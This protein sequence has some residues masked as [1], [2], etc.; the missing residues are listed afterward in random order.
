MAI[1]TV[2]VSTWSDGLFVV[3][4]KTKRQ[5]FANQLVR[6]L[7]SDGQGGA[8]FIVEGHSLCRRTPDGVF[9]TLATSERDLSCCMAVGD[10]IYVGTDDARLLRYAG[11]ANL[12]ALRGFEVV[13]GRDA[14]FAGSAVIDGRVVGPP[15]GIRSMTATSDRAVLLVNVHVG[16]IP[17]SLDGGTTW[18]PTIDIHHDV[19]DVCAH[20]TRP[21][22]VAA[23]AASGLCISR[24]GGTMWTVEQDGLHAPHCS[25]VAFLGDDVVVTASTDPFAAEAAVYRRA[26]DREDLL[27]PVESGLPRWT[28]GIVD[29]GCVA[30]SNSTAAL[31]DRAG[32]VYMSADAGHT[33]AR[34]VDELPV[35]SSVLVCS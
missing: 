29:T 18:Q 2:L 3:I 1:P 12:E 31:I 6:G 15:L 9:S 17:R 13:P 21:R 20:P 7:A 35:A 27:T 5:E 8:L 34:V 22:L 25:A 10:V 26:I 30:V 24:D 19:H 16:G 28:N 33:W 23:A 32:N 11:S 4:G 14:W